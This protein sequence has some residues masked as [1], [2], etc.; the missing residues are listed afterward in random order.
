MS[1]SKKYSVRQIAELLCSG[2]AF[3]GM[4]SAV[5]LRIAELMQMRAFV[6]GA[7]LTEEG[8]ANQGHLMLVVA[9]EAE[10]SSRNL[11]DGGHLV[12]RVAKPGHLIGEVGFVDRQ[13]HSATCIAISEMHVALLAREKFIEMFEVDSHS[14]AQLMA[15]LLRLL[16]LRIR[17]A[18]TYMLA[19]DQQILQLQTEL[20]K[21]QKSAPLR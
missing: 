19:Q 9:G 11:S 10:I 13:A 3:F 15:G 8:A 1:A 17:H 2:E 5:A 6:A 18:N 14:A 7:L 4:P 12:H 20:L 16:A 21:I